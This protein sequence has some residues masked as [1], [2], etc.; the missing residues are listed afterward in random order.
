MSA[1][2]LRAPRWA[3]SIRFRLTVTYAAALFVVGVLVLAGVYLGLSQALD[4]EPITRTFVTQGFVQL[5]DGTVAFVVG[6]SERQFR[7]IESLANERALEQLR[8]WSFGAL[9]AAFLVSLAVGWFVAGRAL[10]PIERIN[11]VARDIQA[12]DLSRRIA[13][14][15]PDDELTRLA[16]TFDDMLGRLDRAFESQRRFVHEASHELRN[17]LA[18]IRTNLEVAL[19]DPHASAE[20]L[21]QTAEVVDRSA[22]RMGD[23][24]DDLLA[25]VRSEMPDREHA[26][27]DMGELVQEVGEEFAGSA[28]AHAVELVVSGSSEQTIRGDPA[29]LRRVLAN[30]VANAIE[31]SPS[32]SVVSIVVADTDGAVRVEVTDRGP[33]IDPAHRELAFSRGWRSA[34]SRD[35]RPSGSGLGLTIVRQVVESHGGRAR[36]GETDGGGAVVVVELPAAGAQV[37]SLE[38]ARPAP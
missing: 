20:D 2:G 4:D 18:T 34:A 16:T 3:R 29:A 8:T 11:A 21:R 1:L 32:G 30:L 36:I 10:R 27:V 12:T 37:R 7:T 33:G 5:D 31:F 22:A 35:M 23:V 24:V 19:A 13:L 6:E 14:S 9:G 25:F 15:G 17:P 38:P 26:L 28:E